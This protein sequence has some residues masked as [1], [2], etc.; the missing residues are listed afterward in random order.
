MAAG[1]P[2]VGRRQAWTRGGRYKNGLCQSQCIPLQVHNAERTLAL[3]FHACGHADRMSG[4]ADV[5][6][7]NEEIDQLL[8][9]VSEGS[10][11]GENLEYDVS[12]SELERVAAGK[13]E[14]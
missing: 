1:R 9:P 11:T 12:F 4:T 13:E 2:M 8:A 10:P 3:S 6:L 7:L 5:V 14:R